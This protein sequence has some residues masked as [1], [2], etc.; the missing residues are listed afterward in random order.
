MYINAYFNKGKIF[1]EKN[2]EKLRNA[3]ICGN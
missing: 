3:Q 2:S 1:S